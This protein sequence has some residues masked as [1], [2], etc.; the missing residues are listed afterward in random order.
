MVM[1]RWAYRAD[2]AVYPLL[3]GA[4]AALDLRAAPLHWLAAAAAGLALWPALEYGLHRWVL[5][6]VPPLRGLH[7]LHHAHPAALIGTPTWVTA[8]LFLLLWSAL[9]RG[10][11]APLAAGATAGLMLGYLLYAAVHDAVHHRAASP[12]TWLAAAKRRHAAHHRP[13]ARCNYGVSSPFWD[14]LLGTAGG[15]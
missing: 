4:S 8:L 11:A 9:A 2:Y 7:A 14:R 13:G 15:A 12:G 6:R 3:I 10:L 1:S 5:H